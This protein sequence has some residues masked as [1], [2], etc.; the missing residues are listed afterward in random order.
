MDF[1]IVSIREIRSIED[2]NTLYETL[3]FELESVDLNAGMGAKPIGR[4]TAYVPD[5]GE[6]HGLTI[7]QVLKFGMR[8]EDETIAY[9]PYAQ[10]HAVG[11]KPPSAYDPCAPCG[12]I[13]QEW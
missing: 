9:D 5:F 11:P 12:S 1:R 3:E 2:S 8:P 10:H 4:L 7:G 13:R 6:F